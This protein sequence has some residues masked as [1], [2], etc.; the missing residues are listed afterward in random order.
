MGNWQKLTIYD[1]EPVWL[2][3]DMAVSIAEHTGH[4]H[5]ALAQTISGS[6]TG[7]HIRESLGDV[8]RLAQKG[9]GQDA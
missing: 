7:Y 8:I 9:G 2:N 3:L 4:T 1:G 5:V 6:L